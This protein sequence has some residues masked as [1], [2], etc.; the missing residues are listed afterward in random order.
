[1]TDDTTLNLLTAV[2]RRLTGKQ[3][4]IRDREP[5]TKGLLGEIH[6][7]LEGVLIV[8]ISPAITSDEKRLRVFLHELA[9]AKHHN[10]LRSDYYKAAPNSQPRPQLTASDWRQEDTAEKQAAEWLEWGRN[11][12]REL[13]PQIYKIAPIDAILISLLAYR[14]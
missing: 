9:H 1:M 13:I 2:A 4:K 6:R 7:D 14:S 11:K 5:A 3:I 10:Y 12:A 8:D